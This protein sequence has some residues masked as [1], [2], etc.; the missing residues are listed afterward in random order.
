MFGAV[1]EQYNQEILIKM[2]S[3]KTGPQ[4]DTVNNKMRIGRRKIILILMY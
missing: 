3:H 2:C 1:I 4:A